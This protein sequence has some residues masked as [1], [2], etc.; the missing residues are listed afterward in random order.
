MLTSK[1]NASVSYV[2]TDRMQKEEYFW[3]YSPLFNY[4]VIQYSLFYL[5]F[6]RFVLLKR[7]TFMTVI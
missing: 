7:I 2:P 3:K 5:T 4:P 1:A 6:M